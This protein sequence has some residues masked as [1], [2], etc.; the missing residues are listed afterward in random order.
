MAI[1]FSGFFGSKLAGFFLLV[2]V[3]IQIIIGFYGGY[4]ADKVGRKRIMIVGIV[5]QIVTY[6]FMTIAN[7]P[8]FE[9]VWLT[10][11]M[12]ILNGASGGLVYP[13][14]SALLIDSST[15]DNRTFMF[16]IQYWTGNV[17][18]MIGSILGGFFFEHHRFELFL[19]LTA[20]SVLTLLLTAFIMTDSFV[21]NKVV[22]KVH[23]IK[24]MARSYK[25]VVKDKA[26][27]YLI[28]ATVFLWSMENHSANFIAVRLAKEFKT[29]MIYFFDF[30]SVEVTG[31]KIIGF[32]NTENAA[33][34]V[35]FG[36]FISSWI[37]N[38]E[39]K[40]MLYVS[41]FMY[42]LGHIFLSVTNSLWFIFIIG[43]IITFGEM[44]ASPIVHTFEAEMMDESSRGSYSAF[45][46]F[47]G[48]LTQLAGALGL[49]IYGWI[50]GY[51]MAVVIALSGI[52]S[53]I[54]FHL[55]IKIHKDN[56]LKKVPTVIEAV[57]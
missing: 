57:N 15:P 11:I 49:T 51:G 32:L 34:V 4:L 21:P 1:Y 24:D 31:Y 2:G 5:I 22:E 45:A 52:V 18:F 17:S 30:T 48:N 54:F 38:K 44:Y 27:M 10:L 7:S 56:K 55:S 29:E 16:S 12:F 47:G 50:G 40:P 25:V 23:V 41:I 36:M 19:G 53:F 20:C 13:A 42:F 9:S 8:M 33:L 26:F 46:N 14:A 37:Q 39:M 43:L 6:F 28:L 35:L 3:W